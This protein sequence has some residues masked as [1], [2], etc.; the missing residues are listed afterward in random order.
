MD[1][2]N[3]LLINSYVYLNCNQLGKILDHI[4]QIYLEKFYRS[5]DTGAGKDKIKKIYQKR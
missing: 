2:F 1:D 5:I 4:E 3:N